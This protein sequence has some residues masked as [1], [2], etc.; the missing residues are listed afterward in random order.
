MDKL[1]EL[2]TSRLFPR[3]PPCTFHADSFMSCSKQAV[4]IISDGY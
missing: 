1:L 2:I 4:A 3:C